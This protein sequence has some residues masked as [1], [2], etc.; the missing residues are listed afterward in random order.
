MTQ[1]QVFVARTQELTQ[2]NDNLDRALEGRGQICFV[3]G[4]A[5]AGKSTLVT[6]FAR[7]AQVQHEDLVVAL[8]TCDAQTG[9]GD[10]YL[11]FRVHL[12]CCMVVRAAGDERADMVLRQAHRL[13][14]SRAAKIPDKA[15]RDSY[16]QN[17]LAHRE[18]MR[19]YAK[20][21]TTA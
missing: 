20:A 8:G 17:R 6:E 2:L 10:P 18:L 9:M 4:E 1:P 15:T 19:A 3:T 11:P 7:R 16:L 21:R 14:Q 5:G 13:L 12:I